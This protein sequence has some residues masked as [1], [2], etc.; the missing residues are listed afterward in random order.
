LASTKKEDLIMAK[1]PHL[2][3]GWVIVGITVVS[4]TLIYGIRHTFSIFF[5]SILD[6]FGWA[7][8]STAIML[9]LNILIYGLLAP[10]AGSLGD[11]WKPTRIMPIGITILALATASCA[12]AH[13][14]WHFYLLFGVLMPIGTAFAGWASPGS[15][16]VKLV[17]QEARASNGSRADGRRF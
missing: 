8:G 17:C 15:G 3:Y 9:S 12:F 5:P 16:T 13:E 7:R 11:R 6:E 1:R 4:L 2:F 14:L 10:V